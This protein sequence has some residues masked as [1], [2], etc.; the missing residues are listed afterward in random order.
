MDFAW[1]WPTNASKGWKSKAIIKLLKKLRQLGRPVFW[2]RFH[3]CA[4]GLEYN[5]LYKRVGLS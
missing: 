3:G 1:E 5:C 2:A 4:Y